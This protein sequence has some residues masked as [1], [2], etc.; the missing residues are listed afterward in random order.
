MPKNANGL[1][2]PGNIDIHHRPVVR[3]PDGTI[4]TVRSMSI[5]T[6]KGEVLIPTVSPDG[7]ILSNQAARDLYRQTGQH[8]GIFKTPDAATAYAKQLHQQQAAEYL[9]QRP[10]APGLPAGPLGGGLPSFKKGGKVKKSGPAILHKGE[11]VLTRK[12]AKQESAMPK[13]RVRKPVVARK[14]RPLGLGLAR[15]PGLPLGGG[16][17]PPMGGG[18]APPMGGGL[19]LPGMKKGGRVKKTGPHMLHKG[20]K[21]VSAAKARK[22]RKH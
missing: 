10:I 14:R 19:G 4:S 17:A 9:P 18:L 11:R 7:R 22:T 20:E 16:A 15:P 13:R 1:I 3:N 5:G 8:L 6:P 21:V 12:Q 2:T